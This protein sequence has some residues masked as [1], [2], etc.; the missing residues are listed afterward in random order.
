MHIDDL[1]GAKDLAVEARDAVLSKLDDGQH[2]DRGEARDRAFDRSRFHVYN[3]G[4][5]HQVADTASS[6][7]LYFDVFDHG[8]FKG[9]TRGDREIK[10]T[11]D[12]ICRALF[13][14]MKRFFGHL[15]EVVENG[16]APAARPMS[17]LAELVR[18]T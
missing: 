16:S 6:T 18:R 14:S 10:I 3:V 4:R 15:G 1:L 9:S 8:A 17:C 11:L 7:L 12:N 13:L 2:P 5:A